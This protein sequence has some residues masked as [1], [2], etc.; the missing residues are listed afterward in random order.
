MQALTIAE[1]ARQIA[2][3]QLSPVE[4]TQHCLDRIAAEDPPRWSVDDD[5]FEDAVWG[6]IELHRT[7]LAW[8][9]LD[10]WRRV[11]PGSSG[12]WG[13]AG[14]ALEVDGRLVEAAAHL[15]RALELDGGNDEA[16]DALRR[17]TDASDPRA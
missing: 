12:A 15:R 16:R 13:A 4:L 9:V 7:D 2:A 10:L 17:V 5:E 11:R 14:W 8:P 6:A 3:R 1:A